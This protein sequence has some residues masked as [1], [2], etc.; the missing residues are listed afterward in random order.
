ML[1]NS[2][3]RIY[4]I[5]PEDRIDELAAEAGISKLLA[6]VFLSRGVEDPSLIK[7]FLNPSISDLHDPFLLAGMDKAVD[8]ILDAIDR[9]E[10]V[11]IYGDYDVDGIT[12]TSILYDFLLSLNADISYFIPDRNTD[13]YGLSMGA[14]ERLLKGNYSLIITVDC[15][16]TAVSEVDFLNQRGIDIIITDHHQCKDTLPSACALINPAQPD[17][18][19]PFKKLSG[20]GVAYKLIHAMGIALGLEDVHNGY[21]D[22]VALGTVADIVP[23]VDENRIIVKYGLKMMENTKNPG[24]RTLIE[25]TGLAGKPL[26]TW[27]AGFILG[28]RINAA[29]RIGDAARGVK[30]FTTED[31]P[32]AQKIAGELNNENAYRQETEMDILNEAVKYIETHIDLGREKI[33]V[34][35]GKGWHHGVIGIVASRITERYSRPSIVLSVEDGCARGSGRSVEG[36]NLFEA[37]EYCKSLL[38]NYG[39]HEL[40]AGLTL[41]EENIEKFREKINEYADMRLSGQ[42]LIPKVFVDVSIEKEDIS[43]ESIRELELLAPFG[44]GNPNPVFE[45]CNISAG[46]VKRVGGNRHIRIKFRDGNFCTDAIGFNMGEIADE[47]CNSKVF[48]VICSLEINR[49]NDSESIQL[50]LKDI[51]INDDFFIDYAFYQ[52]LDRYLNFEEPPLQG[53][54]KARS[55]KM[56]LRGPDESL[57][58]HQGIGTAKPE[59]VASIVL[60]AIGSGK[61]T[62]VVTNSLYGIRSFKKMLRMPLAGIKKEMRIC[63]TDS[64]IFD[65]NGIKVILNPDPETASFE[66]YDCVI[67][68][69]NWLGEAYISKLTQKCRG[70]EV[71]LTAC[72]PECAREL[73]EAIPVREDLEAVYRQLK[74]YRTD[75]ILID[76]IF[77]FAKAVSNN[78]GMNMNFFK[79]KKCLEIFEEL[80]LIK[81]EYSGYLSITVKI[82]ESK[83]VNLADSIVY[84]RLEGYKEF[85]GGIFCGLKI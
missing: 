26:N 29:G 34:V 18:S 43:I 61:R 65:I 39:G 4:R 27:S 57:A 59:K 16:T 3:M 51:R 15:G 81:C 73:L 40:A 83:K 46:E 54:E 30:L 50:N 82:S 7:K 78:Y 12:S 53:L 22:L 41:K 60:D 71:V 58:S 6:K 21:L 49:W 44:C 62:A 55:E 56:N 10:K 68:Y 52:S 9:K 79:V 20:A 8:R 32:E 64:S 67:F 2:K 28:P 70:T 47:I 25:S 35:Y 66:D 45:Y 72:E 74:K 69:G 33:I 31:L 85:L 23:L 42:D 75:T 1:Q 80:G 76:D 19:Y 63:Y 11:L 17:C 38:D 24:L 84:N 37:L 14:I 48:D 36:L 13:G 77:Q 5:Y